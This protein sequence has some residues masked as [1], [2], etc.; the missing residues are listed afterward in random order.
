M[1]KGEGH[2][3]HCC[4]LPEQVFYIHI[5][6]A[7]WKLNKYS[8]EH[9]IVLSS[10]YLQSG[11]DSLSPMVLSLFQSSFYSSMLRTPV[12]YV[13]PIYSRKDEFTKSN[14]LLLDVNTTSANIDGIYQ[15]TLDI[16]YRIPELWVGKGNQ[17]SWPN[18]CII[19]GLLYEHVNCAFSINGFPVSF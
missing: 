6:G 10:E 7:L 15:M 19:L 14:K 11:S 4:V 13:C 2:W 8:L 16:T 9:F 3:K 5:R 18:M 17:S 12:V 1:C